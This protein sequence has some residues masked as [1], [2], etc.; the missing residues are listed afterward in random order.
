ME[1]NGRRH[2]QG[3]QAASHIVDNRDIEK[4]IK[5]SISFT[6]DAEITES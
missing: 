2:H 6:P 4:D 1:S 5:G 3:S